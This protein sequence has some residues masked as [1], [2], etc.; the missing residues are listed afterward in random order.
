[1]KTR[2]IKIGIT[3]GIG[4]GKSEFCKYLKSKK[5]IVINADNL[6]KAL[7]ANDKNIKDQ[8]IETFG[9]ESYKN[10]KPDKKYLAEIV[11]SEPEN[12]YKINS[13]L[14]PV[15]IEEITKLIENHSVKEK[16][17]FVEAALIYEAEMEDLF[18]Y[19]VLITAEKKIRMQRKAK[20]DNMSEEEFLKRN[21]NQVPD[22]E[23][24]K[25]ADFVFENNSSIDELQKKADILLLMLKSG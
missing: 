22:S 3:G 25:A 18:D 24:K 1:M 5:F 12:V 8:I 15:V 14:H 11:F 7:L 2:T 9:T 4:S 21:E 10:N 19:V 17:I 6:S 20:N 23:K 16:I 13:I